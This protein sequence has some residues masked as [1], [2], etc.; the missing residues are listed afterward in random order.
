METAAGHARDFGFAALP[1]GLLGL[2][3]RLEELGGSQ[4]SAARVAPLEIYVRVRGTHATTA[5]QIKA[6]G[7][8]GAAR[9]STRGMEQ[10]R[11][12]ERLLDDL[13][14]RG[15]VDVD[16]L[17]LAA[18]RGAQDGEHERA[19]VW[20]EGGRDVVL[21]QP[22]SRKLQKFRCSAGFSRLASDTD[23]SQPLAENIVNAWLL[24]GFNTTVFSWGK[25]GAG[26]THT[27]LGSRS[28]REPLMMPDA[29]LPDSS[30]RDSV[31]WQ[32]LK[33]IFANVGLDRDNA[34]SVSLSCWEISA[35]GKIVDLLASHAQDPSRS[36]KDDFVGVSYSLD[37]YKANVATM[38]V[39]TCASLVNSACMRETGDSN[40][41]F[42][43]RFVPFAEVAT[44]IGAEATGPGDDPLSRAR[45]QIATKISAARH[46]DG[47]I[48]REKD[49][50][51]ANVHDETDEDTA[52]SGPGDLEFED[53]DPRDD[54]GTGRVGEAL[55]ELALEKKSS[56]PTRMRQAVL[57]NLH[58][59]ANVAK[60]YH[61]DHLE[62]TLVDLMTNEEQ[63]EA[64]QLQEEIEAIEAEQARMTRKK[65]AEKQQIERENAQ[66][67]AWARDM[68]EKSRVGSIMGLFEDDLEWA[69]Q[70]L[71]RVEAA[72]E[73]T[74]FVLLESER[75]AV[76]VNVARDFARSLKSEI[77]GLDQAL[78]PLR[79]RVP[80]FDSRQRFMDSLRKQEKQ[81]DER[82]R[83]IENELNTRRERKNDL[84]S[85]VRDAEA[86]RAALS[87]MRDEL[88]AS[89]VRQSD[90]TIA[91]RKFLSR[92]ANEDERRA[93]LQ[94]LDTRQ[95]DPQA[96]PYGTGISRGV[97]VLLRRL[98]GLVS[99]QAAFMAPH[100]ASL[101]TA[102]EKLGT[103]LLLVENR[104]SKL[105]EA[106]EDMIDEENQPH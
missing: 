31:L 11:K 32:S 67:R 74:D 26:K 39:A 105:L 4:D 43:I 62:V 53:H 33:L 96:Y 19:H 80:Q 63:A 84:E 60:A 29:P 51:H 79:R 40:A 42:P 34:T 68:R 58:H 70:S 44:R 57:E 81:L 7:G 92:I 36:R 5:A 94:R 24:K 49:S 16:V 99:R 86:E 101:R 102:L 9:A 88:E 55:R 59:A 13:A 18:A 87:A 27:L 38:R 54:R 48:G 97:Q 95:Q 76:V 77:R 83:E 30:A 56:T 21:R 6:G 89:R 50:D 73:R 61:E 72:R 66:L 106:M 93:V 91:I 20:V 10:L 2:A 69:R 104:E 75:G 25:S 78:E 12:S 47:D 1:E 8:Q 15:D 52:T 41:L 82:M 103:Q 28:L 65:L 85:G 37:D 17:R 90:E 45:E 35:Q 98:D 46:E 14:R 3:A 64:R 23:V 22:D 100:Q 71:S